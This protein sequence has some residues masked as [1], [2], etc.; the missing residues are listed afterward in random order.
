[1]KLN[2]N[3]DFC[4]LYVEPADEK[5][6][7]FETIGT[8]TRPVVLMLPQTAGQ[9]RSKLFQRPE[10]FNDLKYVKRQTG[11]SIIFLTAGSE[12]LAQMATRYGFP[13][14]PTVDALAE[15]L[16][17]SRKGEAEDGEQ[18][19][20]SSPLHRIRTGPLVP[21]ATQLAALQRVMPSSDQV[22][23]IQQP[24][25]AG[26]VSG[27]V[28]HPGIEEASVPAYAGVAPLHTPADMA[29]W[30]GSEHTVAP[31][32]NGRPTPAP[33]SRLN[34]Y[35][36]RGSDVPV[37]DERYAL[38]TRP[39]EVPPRRSAPLPR[40]PRMRRGDWED[41][42]A[43][44]DIPTHPYTNQATGRPSGVSPRATVDLREDAPVRPVRPRSS[45]N[46]PARGTGPRSFAGLP[47]TPVPPAPPPTEQQ[48]PR[49]VLS[50]VL[51]LLSLLILAGA[52]L[53]SFAMIS[54]STPSATPAAASQSLG[55]VA[56]L[57][58]EQT[59]ADT[60]QGIDDEVQISLHN[61]TTPP[62]G[63]G[64]FAWMLGDLDQTESQTIP[65]GQLTV[66]G[67]SASLLYKGDA[68]HTNLL[69]ITSRF[70]VTEEN[71][72]PTPVL[73]SANTSN[74]IAYGAIPS[75]PSPTDPS[76]FSFLN[77]LRHLLA[78]EPVLDQ[79]EL[80]G[81]LNKWFTDNTEE[82]VSL[83]GSARDDWQVGDITDARD[84]SIRILA[85]LDGM[86]FVVQ[87]LPAPNLNPIPTLNTREAGL[88]L[89]NVRGTGQ[90]PPS[91]MDQF[92]FHLNGLVNA[93]DAPKSL[94]TIV[95]QIQ[96]VL[97]YVNSWLENLRSDVKQLLAMNDEQMGQQAAFS[98]LD[99]MV[100]QAG[101]AYSGSSDPTTGQF[102]E[103]VSWLHQELQTLATI[104]ISTYEPGLNV[105][106]LGPASSQTSLRGNWQPQAEV[107]KLQPEGL[108]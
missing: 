53:G 47:Q 105:P 10:D 21:S 88:G 58:S 74:W 101:N 80:P 12:L 11:T 103:G 63:K 17:R 57:S 64:Y 99:D 104:S 94:Q 28:V 26:E 69:Q 55:T 38:P 50:P 2:E 8:Q 37:Q 107:K 78:D 30:P 96:P 61:L 54:R 42:E 44:Y 48:R 35:S 39:S 19:S 59:N 85:Y 36:N 24:D 51:I 31:G 76:H 108:S 27:L 22:A 86:S 15:A 66:T 33:A 75:T 3:G 34:G 20:H 45:P 32:R 7:L 9:P 62:T 89:L 29:F 93:P 67:G 84:Q 16:A 40:E 106:E 5:Q 68:Q 60:S 6:T 71:S 14:Y 102:R 52:G 73:P 95:S 1:M 65:L 90:N 72:S 49:R 83:A 77:H 82:L 56:F 91:Y 92:A 25:L 81:G 79:L 4:L 98:V 43:V 100:L 13:A 87:D 97:S 23:S 18:R 46:L 70:L 41:D